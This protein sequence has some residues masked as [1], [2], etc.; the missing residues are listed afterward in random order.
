M[1]VVFIVCVVGAVAQSSLCDPLCEARGSLGGSCTSAGVCACEWGWTGRA[2]EYPVSATRY[3]TFLWIAVVPGI[4]VP[5][6]LMLAASAEFVLYVRES[7]RPWTRAKVLPLL[8][9]GAVILAGFMRPFYYSIDAYN[10]RGTVSLCALWTIDYFTSALV[11]VAFFLVLA[12]WAGVMVTFEAVNGQRAW[13]LFLW[14]AMP[15]YAFGASV[16]IVVI[17]IPASVLAC[18]CDDIQC[19]A[20]SG[21]RV[22]FISWIVLNGISVVMSMVAAVTLLVQIRRLKGDEAQKQRARN[23]VRYSAFVVLCAF[24]VLLMVVF[25]SF[26]LAIDHGSGSVDP[27]PS[28]FFTVEGVQTTVFCLQM[29]A[30]I[31]VTYQAKRSPSREEDEAE[32]PRDDDLNKPLIETSTTL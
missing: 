25:V 28:F 19:P 6:L 7:V 23:V 20:I 13:V 4:I 22:F 2:C 8:S 17:V 14:R 27:S 30:V 29:L 11:A 9:C 24:V 21:D 12:R 31:T 5:T 1:F 10:W 15:Y 3:G 32:P 26:L 16:A 18:V